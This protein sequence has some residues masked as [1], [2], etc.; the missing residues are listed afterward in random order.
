MKFNQTVLEY[1][2]NIIQ[3]C[4]WWKNLSKGVLPFFCMSFIYHLLVL[5]PSNY[6]SSN[7]AK[8]FLVTYKQI[9][10]SI[11]RAF[12]TNHYLYAHAYLLSCFS[13][14]WLFVTPWTVA[15]QAPPS[16]GILQARILEWT[17]MPSS[18]G[19]SQPRDWSQVSLTAGRFFT[20]WAR[21]T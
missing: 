17:A 10:I 8:S 19:S 20:I 5:L 18:R 7:Y 11:W 13:H 2:L 1:L 4:D 14:V 16:M 9:L 21:E 3:N 15:C 6:K 12:D